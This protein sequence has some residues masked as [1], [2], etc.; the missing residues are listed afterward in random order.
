[1]PGIRPFAAARF[2]WTSLAKGS[3]PCHVGEGLVM[4]DDY[5]ELARRLFATA[6]AMLED[7]TE[8][9]GCNRYCAPGPGKW[10]PFP[11]KTPALKN[12]TSPAKEA[13]LW[14]NEP[15]ECASGPPAPTG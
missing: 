10:P 1:M 11:P 3:L 4:S 9:R 6:T 14:G 12:W 8:G 7:A 5:R 13:L 15:E 2:A